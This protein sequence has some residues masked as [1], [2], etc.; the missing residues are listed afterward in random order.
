MLTCFAAAQTLSPSETPLQA[1]FR[2]AAE[3]PNAVALIADGDVWSYHRLASE[4]ACLSTGLRRAGIVPGERIVLSVRTSPV[5]AVF[6][7]AAMITSA[8]VVPLK[9]EFKA[10]ELNEFLGWL[11]PALFIHEM[12]LQQVVSLLK[13]THIRTFDASDRGPRSWR[14][15]QGYASRT[16]VSL[17]VDID[18]TFL[19]LAT[20]GT[21]GMPKLV[22]Y[23]QR[24]VSHVIGAL[25]AWPLGPEASVIGC[26]SVAYVSGTLLMLA[27]MIHGCQEVLISHFDADTV[28]DAVEQHSGTTLFV[29]PFTCMPLVQAQRKRPRDISS[30]RT[31]GV[32]G[33]TCLRQVAEAF[34]NTFNLPLGNTYG[35]TECIGSTVFGEDFGALRGVSGRTRL[36]DATGEDVAQGTVGELHLRGPNLSLGYWTGPGDIISHTRN[37]WFATGDLMQQDANGDYRFVGRNYRASALAVSVD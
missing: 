14:H 9:I 21:T 33:N 31:C 8:I 15:L 5:Y 13:T 35:L 34:E 32:G 28:L 20:S 6:L 11:R 24:V 4:V 18:S 26:T 25:T 1:L 23:N 16:E 30:L 36:V 22:A 27:S 17:P 12:E 3:R 29:A 7:F 10:H 19:L 37:G 2:H